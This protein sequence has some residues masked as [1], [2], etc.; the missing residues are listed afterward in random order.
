MPLCRGDIV[1][2]DILSAIV[3]GGS[4]IIS[5]AFWRSHP[6]LHP[7]GRHRICP[8]TSTALTGNAVGALQ[9]TVADVWEGIAAKFHQS[10]TVCQMAV[11]VSSGRYVKSIIIEI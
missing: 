3:V 6:F 5:A 8:G 4:S 2:S 9:Q 10:M 1:Q 11:L 7:G